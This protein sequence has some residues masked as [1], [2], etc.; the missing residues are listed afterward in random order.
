MNYLD[1]LSIAENIFLGNW[2]RKRPLGIVNRQELRS[3]SQ[4]LQAKV[5]IGTH[6]PFEDVRNLSVSEKQPVEIARAYSRNVKVIVMDEPT[7]ALNDRET[8]DLFGLIRAL[9][10]DG[11]SV[12]YISHKLDEVFQIADRVQ[13][14][15]DGQT[16]AVKAIIDT[17]KE[18]MIRLMVGRPVADMYP[19]EDRVIGD[20]VLEVQDL[21][22]GF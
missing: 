12:I 1:D 22:E 7:S 13:V 4:A 14:M 16:V 19:D 18:D 15:R 6:D 11:K 21:N 10:A 9:K 2:P 3:R 8:Q 5:G 20:V 17:T